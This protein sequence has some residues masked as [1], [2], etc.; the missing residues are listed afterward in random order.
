MINIIKHRK[1]E[2]NDLSM[3]TAQ[4]VRFTVF[5]MNF[6]MIEAWQLFRRLG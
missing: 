5:L 4:V 3:L 1:I 2:I 6:V